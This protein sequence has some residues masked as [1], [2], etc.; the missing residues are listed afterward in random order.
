MEP[1]PFPN[2]SFLIGS[3]SC[4][5][6]PMALFLTAQ[7]LQISVHQIFLTDPA[8]DRA[9]GLLSCGAGSAL[10]PSQPLVTR[11]CAARA[12]AKGS[13]TALRR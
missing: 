6:V 9:A 3:S 5:L 10:R 1:I 13:A 8:A 12:K 7:D 11:R 4:F 2:R